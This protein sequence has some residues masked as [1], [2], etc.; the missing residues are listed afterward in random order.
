MKRRI[1][2]VFLIALVAIGT[3]FAAGQSE[4]AAPGKATAEPAE[5]MGEA[6]MLSERVAA[7]EC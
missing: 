5:K 1:F 2:L 3:L 4:A 7:G 6:P